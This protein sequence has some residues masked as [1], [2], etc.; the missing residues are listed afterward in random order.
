MDDYYKKLMEMT[1]PLRN[2]PALAQWREM[3]RRIEEIQRSLAIPS[4]FDSLKAP[5]LLGSIAAQKEVARAIEPYSSIRDLMAQHDMGSLFDES[6]LRGYQKSLFGHAEA[7]E[8]LRKALEPSSFVEDLLARNNLEPLI[9]ALIPWERPQPLFGEGFFSNALK[10]LE[11]DSLIPDLKSLVS[12]DFSDAYES[13]T[14]KI[15]E[16]DAE[17]AEHE[18]SEPLSASSD[19]IQ[20][21]QVEVFSGSLATSDAIELPAQKIEINVL[22]TVKV[23]SLKK[24]RAGTVALLLMLL[25]AIQ[26][27]NNIRQ[28]VVGVVE[29]FKSVTSF[30]DAKKVAKEYSGANR[31]FFTAFRCVYGNDVPLREKPSQKSDVISTLNDGALLEVIERR[32]PGVSKSWICVRVWTGGEYND[33][34]VLRGAT[35]RFH[36]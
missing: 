36:I 1:D 24:E 12:G 11:G 32:S 33:G 8:I 3:D 25:L 19:S 31:E 34:W 35:R 17:I 20:V 4:I 23:E 10:G 30:V 5:S 21:E 6:A 13:L 22:V 9:G 7:T 28:F 16:L 18:D 26:H 29:D 14:K 27:Y 15:A 2:H